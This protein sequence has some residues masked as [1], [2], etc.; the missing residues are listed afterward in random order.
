MQ[1]GSLMEEAW[2]AAVDSFTHYPLSTAQWPV[3]QNLPKQ[4]DILDPQVDS[5]VGTCQESPS[6]PLPPS[7]CEERVTSA[8]ATVGRGA[9]HE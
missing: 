3:E 7:D 9:R 6:I 2:G 8:E 1:K 4:E 5:T